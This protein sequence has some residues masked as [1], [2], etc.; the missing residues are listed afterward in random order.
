MLIKQAL[1]KLNA[2]YETFKLSGIQISHKVEEMVL[3]VHLLD[4]YCKLL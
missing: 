1:G 3:C 2:M 4:F